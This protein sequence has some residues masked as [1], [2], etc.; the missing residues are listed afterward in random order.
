MK[1]IVANISLSM[2]QSEDYTLEV[3][4]LTESEFQALIYDGYSCVGYED[5]AAAINVAYNKEAV[6]CRPGDLL[7]VA[8]LQRGNLKFY[9]IRVLDSRNELIREY[10]E[11]EMTE[12]L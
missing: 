4:K 7:L 2:F 8:N 5:V 9:C 11:E 10:V 3:H 1:Y 6:K 12:W